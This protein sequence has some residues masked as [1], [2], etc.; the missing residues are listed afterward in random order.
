MRNDN[1]LQ[2]C[3]FLSMNKMSKG[4]AAKKAKYYN[5]CYL[6]NPLLCTYNNRNVTKG[7]AEMNVMAMLRTCIFL[8]VSFVPIFR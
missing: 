5:I 4:D 7:V 3:S 6:R 8:T 1:F 2:K